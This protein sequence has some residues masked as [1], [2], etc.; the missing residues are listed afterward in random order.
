[1]SNWIAPTNWYWSVQ[2]SLPGTQVWQSS[3]AS[4]VVLANADYVAFLAAGNLAT[5][6]DTF[7]NLCGSVINYYNQISISSLQGENP[8]I[9]AVDVTLTTPV[10]L[11]QVVN[12]TAAGKRVILPPAYSIGMPPIGTPFVF[13]NSG[14]INT[15]N[16][17][18]AGGGLIQDCPPG[19]MVILFLVSNTTANGG[20]KAYTT[21]S[22][23]DPSTAGNLLMDLGATVGYG[24]RTI[25]GDVS[26]SSVGAATV[27][28]VNGNNPI[29][30]ADGGIG[31]A[32]L[33]PYAVL[34][35]GTAATSALQQATATTA[36]YPL[37]AN[38]SASIASFQAANL[39][40]T[41]VTGTLT[42]PRG[43]IGTASLS[44]YAVLLAGTNATAAIQQATATTAGYPLVANGSTSVSSFQA[45][46]L[47]STF[48]TGTL[49]VTNGGTGNTGGAWTTWSPTVTA[50]TGT[51]TGSVV[52]EAKYQQIGKLVSLH[53][54]I[55]I[56]TVGTA[57]QQLLF[58][59]PVAA[60]TTAHQPVFGV[61]NAVAGVALNGII[62]A[63]FSD[64]SHA[65][66]LQYNA[67]SIFALGNGV[68]PV[69]TA[70][71]EAA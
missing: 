12:M 50:R 68:E 10:V 49:G 44:S 37:V 22:I 20:W 8:I 62:N 55:T 59:L 56:T 34:L 21:Q 63:G 41:F 51:I 40:S 31:T 36:G 13:V 30:V 16:I 35:A 70:T 3:S 6:I 46:N 32:S 5:V 24:S 14:T 60:T 61:E 7:A 19:T 28:A 58:T 42:V 23:G 53:I 69:F 29:H 2:D 18:N 39:A 43:G 15:F 4:F 17:D 52:N 25:F 47:T 65:A 9:S 33:S 45:L 11:C 54:D 26:I 71:Y 57:G 48:V 66:C 27:S 1:M 38:G 64:A 67:A